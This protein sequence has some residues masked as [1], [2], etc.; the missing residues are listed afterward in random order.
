MLREFSVSLPNVKNKYAG[1]EMP[2]RATN[3]MRIVVL[4]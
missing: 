4:A 2:T 3:S 1:N